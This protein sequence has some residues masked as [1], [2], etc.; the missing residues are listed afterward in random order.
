MYS[1]VLVDG[2]CSGQLVS[3]DMVL[4]A[5]HCMQNKHPGAS[6]LVRNLPNFGDHASFLDQ[7]FRELGIHNVET[8]ST[9][10]A[11]WP[12]QITCTLW[13]TR[14]VHGRDIA[15]LICPAQT[16]WLGDGLELS[17]HIGD[18]LGYVE[19]GEAPGVGDRLFKLHGNIPRPGQANI[20]NVVT[21]FSPSGADTGARTCKAVYT[22]CRGQQGADT[23]L[24][25][26][27]G[28]AITIHTG[29][30]NLD[31]RLYGSVACQRESS[32]AFLG[33]LSARDGL[34][35][36]RG[37]LIFVAVEGASTA[38]ELP[39]MYMGRPNLRGMAASEVERF[40]CQRASDARVW[41]PLLDVLHPGQPPTRQ[42]M[43]CQD[44]QERMHDRAG[45]HGTVPEQA[46]W[47]SF[48]PLPT[49]SRA[50]AMFRSSWLCRGRRR[51]RILRPPAD[52][53]NS[54]S[55]WMT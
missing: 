17:Y 7:P 45:C 5:D 20:D 8:R 16:A 3:S 10:V 14:A 15:C 1:T 35:Y 39:L 25:S 33:G 19:L 11:Y 2:G 28:A 54:P 24:G 46:V 36:G 42:L 32:Q 53:T 50:T 31:Y 30:A 37:A 41:C 9:L 12:T 52:G 43:E 47:R 49:A 44:L 23:V 22:G 38:D 13:E 48:I 6:V 55:D 21:L 18:V 4:T 29:D 27:G 51:G 40:G 26:S 34:A